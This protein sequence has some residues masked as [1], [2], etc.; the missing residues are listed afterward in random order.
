MPTVLPNTGMTLPVRGAPG[1]GTWGDTLDAD[2][3][4]IDVMDHTPGHGPRVPVAGL[5]INADLPFSALWAPTQLHHIQFSAIASAGLT[6][7]QRTSLFVS[8]GTSSLVANELYWHNS[9]GNKVQ[10]TAGNTLNFAAFVGGIGGDYTSVN[11]TLNYDDGQKAYEFKEGTIDSHGWARLRSADLRLFPFNTT[12]A[13]YVGHAAPAGIAGTYTVTWPLALPGS[14]L[15]QQIDNAGQ[16]I[17]S[18]TVPSAATFSALIT[19]SVGLIVSAGGAAITGNSSVTGNLNV[20]GTLTNGETRT[21]SVALGIPGPSATVTVGG[22]PPNI[23]LGTATN[24]TMLPL[25][26]K[27]GVTITAWEVRLIKNTD[28][29]KT[30]SAKLWKGNTPT[31]VGATQSSSANAPGLITLGQSSLTEVVT[32]QTGYFIEVV[33]SG[34][35]GDIVTHYYQATTA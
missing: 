35:S 32:T 12:G 8:D 1:S 18:N 23:G 10:I 2:L 26:F 33:G 31:Q 17:F 14:T 11:A 5:N 6:A 28:N 7:G 19:A 29:T 15:L 9:A 3:A 4:I 24:G 34:T 20:T 30:L 13:V 21:Y 25:E 22:S 16:V 27:V